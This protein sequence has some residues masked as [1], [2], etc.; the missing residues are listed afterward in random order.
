MKKSINNF[1]YNIC[2][3]VYISHS[4]TT[5]VFV[6]ENYRIYDITLYIS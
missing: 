3:L 1:I 6:I 4:S 5:T 2:V